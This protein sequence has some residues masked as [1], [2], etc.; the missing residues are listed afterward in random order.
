MTPNT[1]FLLRVALS[2]GA[3]FMLSYMYFG[4]FQWMTVLGLAAFML[5]VAYVLEGLR[6]RR[7]G[8]KPPLTG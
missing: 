8:P 7:G 4:G 6:K 3:A 1:V 5:L 2:I